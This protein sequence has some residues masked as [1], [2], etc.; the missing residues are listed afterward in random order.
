MEK[1]RI[2]YFFGIYLYSIVAILGQ[3]NLLSKMERIRPATSTET[4]ILRL[5]G[6]GEVEENS[7]WFYRPEVI[8][9]KFVISDGRCTEGWLFPKGIVIESQA[10]FV[11]RKKLS[12][13][14]K[15]VEL[16]RFR[17]EKSFSSLGEGLY[18]DD[19]HGVAYGVNERDNTWL[20][21]RYYPA[22]K[23]RANRCK[24]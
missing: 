10:F 2:L 3:D 15:N 21:L 23:F 8:T 4:D 20:S 14:R 22:K 6:R 5:I 19:I 24:V 9:L 17:F 18:F 7:I 16:R 1:F 13:L 12:D 11:K